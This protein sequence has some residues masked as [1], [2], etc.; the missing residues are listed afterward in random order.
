M[1]PNAEWIGA[2]F[3]APDYEPMLTDEEEEII[4]GYSLWA[5]CFC[6]LPRRL[7]DGTWGWGRL[8]FTHQP[9]QKGLDGYRLAHDVPIAVYRRP[10]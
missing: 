8:E 3:A 9:S 2:S 4:R 6:I 1:K 7:I 5:P 10:K